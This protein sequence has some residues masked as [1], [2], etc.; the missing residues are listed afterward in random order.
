MSLDKLPTSIREVL[1]D[2]FYIHWYLHWRYM[3]IIANYLE[4]NNWTPYLPINPSSLWVKTCKNNWEILFIEIVVNYSNEAIEYEEKNGLGYYVIEIWSQTN[5]PKDSV[6]DIN[7][8][9]QSLQKN[10]AD[11]IGNK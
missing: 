5:D 8:W 3:G 7:N 11:I 6:E 1:Y 4:K 9:M 10:T 2:N